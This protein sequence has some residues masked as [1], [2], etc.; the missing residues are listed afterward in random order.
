MKR[1]W[2]AHREAGNVVLYKLKNQDHD[3]PV[4]STCN[5]PEIAWAF[6]KSH[7]RINVEKQKKGWWVQEPA[8]HA[9]GDN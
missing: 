5:I 4:P 1:R 8:H 7:P 9:C 3:M 2:A 6:F